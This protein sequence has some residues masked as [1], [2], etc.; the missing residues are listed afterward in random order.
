MTRRL[1]LLLCT[2]TVPVGAA[3]VDREAEQARLDAACAS[4]RQ[5]LI[6]EGRSQRV[7]LCVK[8]GKTNAR[9]ERDFASFGQR[10]GN[11]RPDFSKVPACMQ[12]EQYRKSYR[13]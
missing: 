1:F 13:Q 2:L 7:A 3:V 10:E 6:D 11:K 12:A 9:C 5:Q 4:A 8:E